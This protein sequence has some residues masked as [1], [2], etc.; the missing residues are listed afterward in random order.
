[1]TFK[2]KNTTGPVVIV[3]KD[4]SFAF[5]F[6]IAYLAGYLRQ[7]GEDVRVLFRPDNPGYY[8]SFIQEI[9]ALKPLI[10]G[11][12]SLYP[13]L[14][15][16]V[17]L[18]K[19]LDEEGRSFPVVIGGQMV[20]P[21]PE[22]AVKV[23]GADY[24]VIG[25]GEIILYELVTA[26]RERRDPSDV[27]GL[28]IRDGEEIQS[29]GLGAFINDLSQLPPIP[30]DLFP[31]EKW[32]NIG[33]FYARYAQ[34]HWHYDDRVISIHGGRGCPYRC[35]FCYHH[36]KARY[37]SISDMMAEAD[38]LLVRYNA[39][40]LYFGDDLVLS[41]PKRARELTESLKK[42]SRPVEYSVS[43]RFDILSRID[44][45]LLREMRETGCRIMGLGI[46]SGS[47]RILDIMNKNITVEQILSGLRRLKD[48][49]I[50]PTVSI[51]VGQVSETLED[52][53]K[54][55]SLMI[56][57]VRY[58]KRIQYAFTI[59]TPFP[60][61][62]LYNT[63][64]KKGILK[65]H[66]DFYKRFSPATQM[67]GLSVNLSDMSDADVI[68]MR[69][70]LELIFIR[71]ITKLRGKGVMKVEATRNFLAHQESFFF[72]IFFMRLPKSLRLIMVK[73]Y[74]WL[75]DL[76]Q[77]FLD[78]LRLKMLGISKVH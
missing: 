66:F 60:G 69:N 24:G 4:V 7:K 53:G 2:S 70:E 63:A 20:S 62:D 6:G 59:T 17:K 73:P 33:K 61:S 71:E 75:F 54:S 52:V 37:R 21:T 1:M 76:A 50:L 68:K 49:G 15:A 58:D 31:S 25:E 72:E 12:G 48:V 45:E 18:T 29:T 46:E 10:V 11:F 64:F 19:I 13:D 23:T 41:S 34:P 38:E 30:Y 28:V 35:N 74:G 57:T 44:D 8:K 26:L 32:L 78:K 40:V 56:E 36:S 43:C 51:M 47:Q 22:F 3:C 16:V 67:T 9:I 5:P 65:N 27:K 77:T 39:N 14:Y 55:K 42:L